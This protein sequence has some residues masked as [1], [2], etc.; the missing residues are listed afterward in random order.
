MDATLNLS[1]STPI[2]IVLLLLHL[3]LGGM[4]F[5]HGYRKLF[6]GG[7]L[8]GTA[9]WFESIG[10]RPGMVNAYAAAFTEVGT[11][12]L[13]AVGLLTPFACAALMALMLVAIVSVHRKNGF[14]ITN[15]GGGIE[16]CLT[17]AVAALTLGTL[18]A[19]RFSLD[20]ALGILSSWTAATNFLVTLVVGVGGA[21]LQLA[22]MYRPPR[23]IA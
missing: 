22:V 10:M 14:M 8:A 3:F 1:Y 9:R 15:P 7:K 4:I 6:R 21:T 19:G 18:G 11:G 13:L 23:D 5:A 16:Y 12:I 20:H 17:L 2:N